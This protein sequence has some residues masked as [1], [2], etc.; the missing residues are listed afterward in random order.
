MLFLYGTVYLSD[1]VVSGF[2][3]NGYLTSL[4]GAYIRLYKFRYDQDVLHNYYKNLSGDEIADV[5]VLTTISHTRRPT[6][7]Y[8]KRNKPTSFNKLDDR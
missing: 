6:S 5:N 1:Y 7:K 8:R 4:N 2:C 3:R